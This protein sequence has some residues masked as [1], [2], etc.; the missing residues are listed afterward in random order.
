MLPAQAV[1]WTLHNP[2]VRQTLLFYIYMSCG[3]GPAGC[4]PSIYLV[5]T[6]G[7]RTQNI[8]FPTIFQVFKSTTSV[9]VRIL[10]LFL[11]NGVRY[12]MEAIGCC[13][14]PRG[15]KNAMKRHCCLW[16]TAFTQ[17]SNNWKPF[18]TPLC[19]LYS[20][21][22]SFRVDWEFELLK[23]RAL[24]STPLTSLTCYKRQYRSKRPKTVQ[25]VRS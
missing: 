11:L 3:G 23:I 7:T 17:P 20:S 16:N 6:Q 2:H 4:P 1:D 9:P 24:Q 13:G 19:L 15:I 25:M 14:S 18:V 22:T 12:L 8:V 5:L 10:T 21:W